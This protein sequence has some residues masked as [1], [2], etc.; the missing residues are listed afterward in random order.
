MR[1]W[2]SAL[3]SVVVVAACSSSD[4]ETGGA[5]AAVESG[6]TDTGID[7]SLVGCG[8][9]PLCSTGCTETCGCCS[10]GEGEQITSDGGTLVCTGGCY[11]PLPD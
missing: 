11:A 10:C 7:C 2:I 1:A 8:A 6:S 3:L 9:P 5:D 4:D